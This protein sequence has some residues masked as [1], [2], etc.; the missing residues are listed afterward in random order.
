MKWKSFFLEVSI[1]NRFDYT[2]MM[3][4][5]QSLYTSKMA[6]E[7]DGKLIK[8]YDSNRSNAVTLS[9]IIK[10]KQKFPKPQFDKLK[11]AFPCIISSVRD[12]AEYINLQK[13]LFDL[14]I[15]DEASQVSIL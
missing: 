11:T 2:S 8:F 3:K 6:N 13:D 5:L 14:I 4:Q 12:F 15:I 7:L 1:L 10:T 9:K